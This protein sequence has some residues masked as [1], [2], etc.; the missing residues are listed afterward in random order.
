[1][2]EFKALH[3]GWDS[4]CIPQIL[5][6]GSQLPQR[7]SAT[8]DHAVYTNSEILFEVMEGGDRILVGRLDW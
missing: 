6:R 1:M 5:E 7:V 4:A 3:E 8:G 2:S